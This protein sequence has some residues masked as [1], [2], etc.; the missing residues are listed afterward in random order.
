[1]KIG[2]HTTVIGIFGTAHPS[3]MLGRV[4]DA[5]KEALQIPKDILVLYI[6]PDGQEVQATL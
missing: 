4:Y 5:A 6:G 3:R 2:E 1:M